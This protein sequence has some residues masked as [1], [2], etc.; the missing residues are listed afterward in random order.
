MADAILTATGTCINTVGIKVWTT[1]AKN[2]WD[3]NDLELR[4]LYFV[5]RE[6]HKKHLVPKIMI[7]MNEHTTLIKRIAV[8]IL[9]EL[10]ITPLDSCMAPP[11]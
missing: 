2:N 1:R 9:N 7:V 4:D 8:P 5:K 3:C 11:R 10:D 6:M